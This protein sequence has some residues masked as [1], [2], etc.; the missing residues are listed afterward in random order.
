MGATFSWALCA[1]HQEKT[2]LEEAKKAYQLEPTHPIGRWMLS[3]AYIVN[4]NYSDAIALDEQWLVSEPTSQFALRDAAIAYAKAGNADKANA[5]IRRLQEMSKTQYVPACRIA[6]VYAALGQK[7]K[8][9]D[10]LQKSFEARDWE[11]HRL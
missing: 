9:F 4:N 11:L 7:D 6:A 5:L 8:A 1:T 2:G 3:Q 10:E